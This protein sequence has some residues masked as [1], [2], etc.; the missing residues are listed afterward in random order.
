M[1]T[2]CSLSVYYAVPSLQHT[3]FGQPTL[4]EHVYTCYCTAVATCIG[5]VSR[6]FLQ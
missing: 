6:S 2:T 5:D 1:L 4:A 3:L